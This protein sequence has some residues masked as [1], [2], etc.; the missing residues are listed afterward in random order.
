MSIDERDLPKSHYDRIKVEE[1]H[2][3]DKL[4]AWS[5]ENAEASSG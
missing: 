1:V 2:Y 3:G 5:A 4:M